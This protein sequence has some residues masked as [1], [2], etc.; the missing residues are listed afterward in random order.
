MKPTRESEAVKTFGAFVAAPPLKGRHLTA[1]ADLWGV[2][3]RWF[4]L[5]PD[6]MLRR[7]LMA[8][9][10]SAGATRR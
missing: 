6:S 4:G 5:E 2:R 7:R 3:R 1:M 9:V 8:V 10:L